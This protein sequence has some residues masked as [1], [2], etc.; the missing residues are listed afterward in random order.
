MYANGF[1]SALDRAAIWIT[2]MA[3]LNVLWLFYCLRGLVIGGFFPATVGCLSV[4]RKWLRGEQDVKVSEQM[5]KGYKQEFFTSNILGWVMVLIGVVL[6]LNYQVMKA[7]T[8]DI[9]FLVPFFFFAM[10]FFYLLVL[11]WAFPLM[12]HYNGGILQHMKNAIV[13]GLT[14]LH[15]SVAISITLF[16]LVYLS[17]EYPT[18]I[19]FFLFSLGSLIWYWLASRIFQK[20][21]Q[22]KSIQHNHSS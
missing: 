19:L 2:R 17:L 12:A 21:D 5:K 6:Y 1:M 7:S 18:I 13:I 8:A 9:P 4:A 3:H 16:S 22:S 14:K 11:V 20:L 15:I 10:L